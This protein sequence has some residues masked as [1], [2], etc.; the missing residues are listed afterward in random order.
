[1]NQLYDRVRHLLN[2]VTTILITS[3]ELWLYV[4]I[5]HSYVYFLSFPTLFGTNGTQFSTKTNQRISFKNNKKIMQ[6]WI[7]RNRTWD[8]LP[9]TALEIKNIKFRRHVISN[10]GVKNLKVAVLN[11]LTVPILKHCTGFEYARI[12]MELETFLTTQ[13]PRVHNS[14]INLIMASA[15]SC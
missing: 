15:S 5:T 11:R 4:C 7:I 14:I 9:P 6:T 1:L 8:I 3:V 10:Y 12:D 13:T 2:I